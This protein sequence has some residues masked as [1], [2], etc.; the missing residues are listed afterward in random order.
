M[1]TKQI[2]AALTEIGNYSV[3]QLIP[4]TEVSAIVT[5]FQESIYPDETTRVKFNTES[6]KELLEVYNG[7]M[8]GDNFIAEDFPRFIIPFDNIIG[9]YLAGP[10]RRKSP[11]KVGN[12]I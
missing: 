3:N 9:F 5:F 1:T 11:Y 6:G 8:D 7:K 10:N 4:L 2:T 12:S